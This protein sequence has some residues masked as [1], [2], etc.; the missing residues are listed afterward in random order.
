MRRIRSKHTGDN[1]INNCEFMLVCVCVC[2]YVCV[3]GTTCRCVVLVHAP[4]IQL[5]L[6]R[7]PLEDTADG[8]QL[9]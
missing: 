8:I 9:T 1:N 3:C 2:V 7:L 5:K 4:A 6:F